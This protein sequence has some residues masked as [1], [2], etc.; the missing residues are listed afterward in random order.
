MTIAL[1]ATVKVCENFLNRYPVYFPD[2]PARIRLHA[3]QSIERA[4]EILGAGLKQLESVK[5]L[6]TESVREVCIHLL[7]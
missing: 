3:F 4:T 1:E 7:K 5:E 6:W 2:T